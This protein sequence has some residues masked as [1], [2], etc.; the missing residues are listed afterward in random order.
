MVHRQI[1]SFSISRQTEGSLTDQLAH[2]ELSHPV[3][4]TDRIALSALVAEL[5]GVSAFLFYLIY[6][7]FEGGYSFHGCLILLLLRL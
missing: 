5:D 1:S 7:F 2:T 6:Y 4:G 3:P